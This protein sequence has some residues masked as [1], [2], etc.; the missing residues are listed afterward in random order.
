MESGAM[1]DMPASC[2]IS[3]NSV[4]EKGILMGNSEEKIA[5]SGVSGDD[6]AEETTR[7]SSFSLIWFERKELTLPEI[8]R[9][10]TM[11]AVPMATPRQV[12]KERVRLARTFW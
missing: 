9:I 5:S 11:E 4:V 12:R 3:D 10:R 7:M 6:E 1:A 8:E 2:R